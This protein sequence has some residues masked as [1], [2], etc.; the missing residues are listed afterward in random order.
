MHTLF[1]SFVV[2]ALWLPLHTRFSLPVD[3]N[4]FGQGAHLTRYHLF[5]GVVVVYLVVVEESEENFSAAKAERRLLN[6]YGAKIWVAGALS[7]Q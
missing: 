5:S 4:F 7:R 2:S 1:Q 3:V 6:L